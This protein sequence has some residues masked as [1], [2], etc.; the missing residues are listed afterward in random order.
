MELDKLRT[1]YEQQIR[2]EVAATLPRQKQ[3]KTVEI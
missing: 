2:E 1:R 3:Q